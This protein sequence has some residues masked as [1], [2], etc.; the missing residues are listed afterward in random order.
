M[1]S[2]TSTPQ[3]PNTAA[4][5]AVARTV[6]LTMNHEALAN[7]VKQKALQE[8]Y[9]S[10]TKSAPKPAGSVPSTQII[11]NDPT[12]QNEDDDMDDFMDGDEE[13]KQQIRSAMEESR[14]LSAQ[15]PSTQKALPQTP[16][17]VPQQSTVKTPLSPMIPS[18]PNL[19]KLTG[20]PPFIPSSTAASSANV[21]ANSATN[22][23]PLS[24][25]QSPPKVDI[26]AFANPSP[27][28]A[29]PSTTVPSSEPEKP[30]FSTDMNQRAE[31]FPDDDMGNGSDKSS[32]KSSDS[33]SD[34]EK[35]EDEKEEDPGTK[36]ENEEINAAASMRNEE[37]MT[38]DEILAEKEDIFED[39]KLYID[40]GIMPP[41][42]PTWDMKL[43]VLRRIRRL[44]ERTF[45]ETLSVGGMGSSLVE[46]MRLVENVNEKFDP[47]AKMFGQGMKLKGLASTVENNLPKYNVVLT[48]LHRRYFR[49]AFNQRDGKPTRSSP[50][51]QLALITWDLMKNVHKENLKKEMK[52]QAKQAMKDP[53][54]I[55]QAQQFLQQQA[56]AGR[57]QARGQN[58]A[59]MAQGKQAV[60]R[61]QQR[62]V[63]QPEEDSDEETSDDEEE[64]QPKTPAARQVPMD[65]AH[66]EAM[67]KAQVDYNRDIV[68]AAAA[69]LYAE[70]PVR[71]PP[72]PVDMGEAM[73]VNTH[74]LQKQQNAEIDT[75]I[76]GRMK[77][78]E[79]PSPIIT[80]TEPKLVKP[81][82]QGKT[83]AAQ[84]AHKGP[85]LQQGKQF[86]AMKQIIGTQAKFDPTNAP[87]DDDYDEDEDEYDESD[88]S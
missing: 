25:P 33:E 24:T 26:S 60:M 69:N 34:S 68:N 83:Q 48:I 67:Q 87:D 43:S 86:A 32:K 4:L 46:G 73:N 8:Q 7:A 58:I 3:T 15:T 47:F 29:M 63:Q 30:M 55:L 13:E 74:A 1:S 14:R 40:A 72:K 75:A 17:P 10:T 45:N 16:Q 9:L 61:Q 88:D 5:A 35:S 81:Q 27:S 78:Y 65:R 85:A 57:Q 6:P 20:S 64:E 53:N 12:F 52:K 51:M 22:N 42:P 19:M 62:P 36:A 21:I 84:P 70:P 49:R 66:I 54:T 77:Q 28:A 37:D 2:S 18:S 39:I 38:L 59:K 50:F 71:L 82:V 56:G 80:K 23:I 76:S 31:E 41:V 44:M 79:K 11:E